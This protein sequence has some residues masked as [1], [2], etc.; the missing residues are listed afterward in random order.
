MEIVSL[1][2]CGNKSCS[3]YLSIPTAKELYFNAQFNASYVISKQL[4]NI[5]QIQCYFPLS[6]QDGERVLAACGSRRLDAGKAEGIAECKDKNWSCRLQL[7]HCLTNTFF[8][9]AT[10]RK[11]ELPDGACI[12][13]LIS[14]PGFCYLHAHSFNTEL[15]DKVLLKRSEVMMCL[16]KIQMKPKCLWPQ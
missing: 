1:V 6:C 11:T 7:R 12:K 13:N 8:H 15:Q 5:L 2:L 3:H 14:D 10:E 9:V 4:R 16:G